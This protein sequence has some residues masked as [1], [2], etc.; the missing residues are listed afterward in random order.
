MRYLFIRVMLLCVC[1]FCVAPIFAQSADV[2]GT[3]TDQAGAVVRGAKVRIVNQRTLV[4]RDVI[5]NSQGIFSAPFISPDTYQIVVEAPGFATEVVRDLK[6]DA[7]AKLSLPVRLRVG[8]QNQT[9]RVEGAGL[10]LNTVDASVG[11]VVDRTFVENTPLNG[12][13]FQDLIL[14]TPGVVTQSPQAGTGVGISGDFSVNGQRTESNYYTVDG[15]SANLASGNGGGG[16]G[17]FSGGAVPAATALGTTQSLV[18][19]DALQEF[20]VQSSTYSAEFGHSPGGQISFVTRSG[21]NDLHGSAFDYL[22]NNF[23][24]AND[25]F[26]DHYGDP[27]SALRQNDF[28][29]TFGGPVWIPRVY[30]GQNKTF[31]FVSYEGLRLSQPQAASIQYV[32]DSFLR[33]SPQL[34]PAIKQILN[35]FPLPN[36]VDYGTPGNPSLAQF[37]KSYSIP[38]QIDSTSVRIDHTFSPKLA[39]FFRFGDTPSYKSSRYLSDLMASHTNTLTYTLGVAGHLAKNL[40]NEFRLGYARNN[41]FVTSTID[42]F[43][44]AAPVNLPNLMGLGSAS[45]VATFYLSY[46][47]IGNSYVQADGPSG[48]RNEGRQ[49]NATDT[50]NHS[51]GKHDLRY[52]IDYRRIRIPSIPGNP[53]AEAVFESTNSV[54]SNAADYLG[55]SKL[56][57][58]E[59][60]FNEIAVFAQDEWHASSRIN[61]SLGLRW[62]VNPPPSGAH[63]NDAYTVFGDPN[64]PST[65]TLAPRG[66]P[67]WKT[68]WYNFAPRLGLAYIAHN[69]TGR[70]TVVR[71]GGGVFFDTNNQTASEGFEGLGFVANQSYFGVPVPVTGQQLDFT[72]APSA[73]YTAATVV[74]FSEHLQLPYTLQWN[75]SLEQAIGKGQA[76][77][78][79]YV[80]ANGRRLAQQQVF[81]INAVNPNFGYINYN[82]G[83]VS[84]SYNSLQAKY[85]RTIAHG[86]QALASYTWSH[87][88]DFGSTY[89]ANPQTRGNS[90]FD[91][92]NSFNGALTWELPGLTGAKTLQAILNGWG[93]DARVIARTAFPITLEGQYLIDP[94]TGN[95]YYG[96]V[97]SVSGQPIYLY[98]SE[99]P[100]GRSVNPAAF[101]VPAGSTDPGDAPR[102]LVRGFGEAQANLA[103]RRDFKIFDRLHLQFRAEAF[104]VLNHPNFG[105]VDVCL[106]CAQFGQALSMLNQSLGTVAPQYQQGGPRSMQFAIKLVY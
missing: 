29:G 12:R 81:S 61:V 27:I 86:I 26:N 94:S 65:L 70:E 50:L 88:L 19:V 44:G 73:P 92:R 53:N 36:G 40:D 100:G 106:T 25:W 87:A 43:G 62:E 39:A 4:E 37:I 9:V 76:A 104:N 77:T 75:V 35:A 56:A 72:T 80:G 23:F 28:G 95:S 71:A 18:S 31:F 51:V 49:W 82:V 11:T 64:N 20:K 99:Y 6:I 7:T 17:A 60:I 85:Q 38:S 15:V 103:A 90:D 33:Q 5:T 14:L 97:D 13:S 32:P 10:L 83:D 105:S 47:E 3:V 41:A 22:R 45:S 84:S 101:S 96:N 48:S 67:L 42:G 55:V 2:S 63:R 98:G 102:N 46:P 57:G 59:P 58:S 52:G 78:L 91:V 69:A 74:A 30:N 21:T 8:Q 79:S 34:A 1:L 68:A 24:D 54:L 16:Q 93:V 66:T 89:I